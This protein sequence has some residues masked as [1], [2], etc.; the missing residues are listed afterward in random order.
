MARLDAESP[1]LTRLEALLSSDE[2]ARADQYRS[3]TDSIR[4]VI[5]RAALRVG[6]G[7]VLRVPP[8]RIHF[9]Y[10]SAGKPYVREPPPARVLSFNLAHSDGL[11]VFA[12]SMGCAVGIDVERVHQHPD[13]LDVAESCFSPRE[14]RT[15]SALSR[16]EQ[17]IAF[18]RCWTRK[19]AYVKAVGKGLTAPLD[20]F[21]VTLGA[22]ERPALLRVR[23]QPA[24]PARWR[25]D[26]LSVPAGYIGALVVGRC[27]GEC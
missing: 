21:D 22:D 10:G 7:R 15:L 9:G 17:T 26:A 14:R 16:Q 20:D 3:A 6:L 2:R 11:A 25:M 5:R 23:Q 19:E 24:E 13:L 27:D 4:F 8:R 18:Y 1:Q 12:C